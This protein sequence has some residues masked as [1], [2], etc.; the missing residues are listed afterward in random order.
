MHTREAVATNVRTESNIGLALMLITFRVSVVA[1]LFV[2]GAIGL[3]AVA[4]LVGGMI[5]AGSPLGLVEGW[6]SAVSGL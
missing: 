1:T 6:F 5:S 3:F 4:S 2:I